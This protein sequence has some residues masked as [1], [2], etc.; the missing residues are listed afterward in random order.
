VVGHRGEGVPTP[1]DV[2]GIRAE[3]GRGET[4]LD[5]AAALGCMRARRRQPHEIQ[6]EHRQR[7]SWRFVHLKRCDG[8]RNHMEK[9]S[10]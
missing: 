10:E 8:G 1:D 3:G 7:Q 4:E 5:E 9:N 2:G 6:M